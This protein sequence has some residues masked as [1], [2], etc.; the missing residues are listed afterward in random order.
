[1]A[2]GGIVARGSQWH[3]WDPHIHTPG[4]ALNDQFGGEDPWKEFLQRIEDSNPPIRALGITDYCGVDGYVTATEKKKAG[5]LVSI[6]LIFPNVEFRLSIETNKGPGINLHLLFSPDDPD[7]VL[8]IRRFL[9]GIEFKYAGETFRCNRDDLTR[10]GRRHNSA[11]VKDTDAYREG[12]NQFKANFDEL[13]RLWGESRWAQDNCLFAIAAGS[14][15]GTS[16]LQGEGGAWEA[17]RKKLESAANIIFSANPKTIAFFLGKGSITLAELEKQWKGKKPCLHGSDAHNAGTVGNPPLNRFCWLKGDLTFETIRQAVIEPEG[18]VSIGEA[19]PRGALPGNSIEGVTVSAAP[20]MSPNALPMNGGMVA[21]IGARGS[22]K[23]AL[24]D[25]IAVGALGASSQLSDSS[26][27]HRA[28]EY[29]GQSNVSLKWESGEKTSNSVSGVGAEDLLD[30]PHVQ[31]LSQQFV[32][33]L[34]SSEG[35][36]DSLVQEIERVVFHAH[37]ESDRLGADSFASLLDTRLAPAREKR[38]RQQQSLERSVDA[39]SKEQARKEGLKSAIK[40]RDDKKK[41]IEKDKNDRKLLVPKGQEARTKQLELL[42][43]EVESRQQQAAAIQ[44]AMQDLVGLQSDVKDFRDRVAPDWIAD[45]REQR[46]DCGLSEADWKKFEV[47]FVSDVDALLAARLTAARA[48]LKLVEGA[49]VSKA[50]DELTT[51]GYSYLQAGKALSENTL[52]ALERERDL[53]QRQVGIDEQNARRYRQLSEN[54]SRGEAALAKMNSEIEKTG[55]SDEQIKA[56]RLERNSAYRGIFE[57]VVQEETHLASLYAPLAAQLASGAGAVSKL[58]FSV[59]RNVDFDSWTA[60]GEALLD[61]RTGP[62]R[63]RGELRKAVDIELASA[64]QSGTA[65]QVADAMSNFVAQNAEKLKQHKPAAEDMREWGKK[66]VAWLYG[67]SHITV[68]YGLQ[69]DGVD[70]ER[71][72]P[73]TRGIVLLLLYLAIDSNDDRPLIIDQPEENLDP[74]SVFDELV[75]VFREAKMRRQIIVVTHNANLVVN[76][77]VDQVIVARS[78]PHRPG[79]LPEISY[80]SGGLENAAIRASVCSILEGGERAFRERAKRLRVAV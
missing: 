21:I 6:D 11:L 17:T 30:F 63:G 77:D 25:L 8:E 37:A 7:H 54:I 64:L 19:P 69:Y 49:A 44:R 55:K 79:Q 58:S 59:R 38:Y 75:P 70:I 68:G 62:F 43:Q 13:V 74:Q 78:G 3:R 53:K 67:T 71:L 42:T 66:V 31:Y 5:S 80:Q 29:L 56:F 33:R 16:G 35:L 23:T 36:G 46:A 39:I 10:L 2:F 14:H 12:V 65:Q 40:E 28:K 1:M 50:A 57:A 48:A 60:A 22:G 72:S 32:E 20:W 27:I 47:H 76:T 45:V 61:L 9:N 18:R 24:A 52:R 51:P 41:G 26:F 73:G 4:T 15:D 34:C